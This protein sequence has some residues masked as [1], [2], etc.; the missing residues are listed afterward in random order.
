MKLA[1]ALFTYFPYGGLTRDAIA[2]VRA[3]QQR[4]HQVRMYAR[5]CRNSMGGGANMPADMAADAEIE[6][7]LLLYLGQ[8]PPQSWK[9]DQRVHY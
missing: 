2:I 1:F 9:N 3:C 6:A 4:G 8:C 5:E 7:Q